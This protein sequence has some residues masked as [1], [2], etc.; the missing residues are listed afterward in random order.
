MWGFGSPSNVHGEDVTHTSTNLTAALGAQLR[1]ILTVK[2]DGSATENDR[3]FLEANTNGHFSAGPTARTVTGVDVH[4]EKDITVTAGNQSVYYVVASPTTMLLS[5][6]LYLRVAQKTQTA[7]ITVNVVIVGKDTGGSAQTYTG[8]VWV[9]TNGVK[10]QIVGPSSANWSEL[11]SVTIN[12]HTGLGGWATLAADCKFILSGRSLAGPTSSYSTVKAFFDVLHAKTGYTV[13]YKDYSSES[14][15]GA[16]EYATLLGLEE[17]GFMGNQPITYKA[18]GAKWN[19]VSAVVPLYGNITPHLNHT[20]VGPVTTR[21]SHSWGLGDYTITGITPATAAISSSNQD[22]GFGDPPILSDLALTPPDLGTT[23]VPDFGGTVLK[24]SG[25][26]P[27][28]GPYTGYLFDASNNKFGPLYS[29]FPGD[30]TSLSTNKPRKVLTVS[31]PNLPPGSYTL[32]LYH[33]TAS[34]EIVCTGTIVVVRRHRAH[35][36]YAIR[37]N[38]PPE[39]FEVGVRQPAREE[40]IDLYDVDVKTVTV[41]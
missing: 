29:A 40:A 3:A 19:E 16:T 25:T 24:L 20:T 35:A 41:S 6:P 37:K 33:G 18:T 12:L 22:Y 28:A 5:G 38:Y 27:T 8:N 17:L 15:T 9:A 21:T 4:F 34:T 14:G 7:G 32:K 11:T 10:T 1:E 23:L 39:L 26:F 13:A 30:A 2:H 31:L 36:A